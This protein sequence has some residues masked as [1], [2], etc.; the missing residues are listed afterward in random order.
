MSSAITL[1]SAKSNR[2]WQEGY[3]PKAIVGRNMALQK[4]RYVHGNPVRAGYVDVPEA[5]R[6]SSAR[7]Y[8]EV[9]DCVVEIDRLL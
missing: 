4:L 3:H 9:G 8:A 5:W 7:N 2:V 1:M 6:Y